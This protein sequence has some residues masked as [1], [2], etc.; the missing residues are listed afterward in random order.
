MLPRTVV[1]AVADQDGRRLVEPLRCLEVADQVVRAVGVA[2]RLCP[3]DGPQARG[4]ER[5]VTSGIETLLVC[6]SGNV[7]VGPTSDQ[8][9]LIPHWNGAGDRPGNVG[10]GLPR[11]RLHPFLTGTVPAIPSRPRRAP[12]PDG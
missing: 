9:T 3:V 12:R 8:T 10:W 5:K 2:V 11:T 6:R 4:Q 1:A 7:G